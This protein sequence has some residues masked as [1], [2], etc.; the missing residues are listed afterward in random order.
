MQADGS[1]ITCDLDDFSFAQAQV[2]M[3]M[4]KK[5]PFAPGARMDD[6]LLDLVLVRK[7]GGID[8]LRANALARSGAHVALPFVDVIRCKSYTLTPQ[9]LPSGLEPSLNLDGELSGAAPFQAA[10]VPGALDVF[11]SQLNTEVRDTSSALE[12]Q[13]VLS[14]VRLLGQDQD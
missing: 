11:V 10:C 1:V 12:P 7:S 9:R 2:N 14:V 13:L 3:H 4:G 8:I 6:G 5:V